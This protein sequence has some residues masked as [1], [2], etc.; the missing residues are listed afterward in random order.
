[1]P[2]LEEAVRHLWLRRMNISIYN[3][4]LCLLPRS[5]WSFARKSISDFKNEYVEECEGCSQ[6]NYCSGMFTSQLSRYSEHIKRL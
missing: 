4:Q 2:E 3:L 5:L 6:R 1:M